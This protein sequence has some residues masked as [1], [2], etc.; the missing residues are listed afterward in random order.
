MTKDTVE[1]FQ[2]AA[3]QLAKKLIA[4]LLIAVFLL[5]LFPASSLA[6]SK[7][8]GVKAT[9]SSYNSIK[10]SWKKVTGASGYYVYQASSKTGKYS[11]VKTITSGSTLSYTKSSLTSGKAYYYKVKAYQTVNKVK[12]ASAYSSIVSAKPIPAKPTNFK[13]SSISATSA[14][15]AWKKVTGASGYEIY[16]ATSKTGKY[17]KIATSTKGSSVSYT[18]KNLVT[19]KSYYYKLR[20]YKKVA[21]KKVYGLYSPVIRAIPTKAAAQVAP[22]I[23]GPTSLA[24]AQGYAKTSSSIYTITGKPTPEV[25][26]TAGN[27]KIT[28][29]AN[30]KKLDIAPGLAAGSYKVTLSAINGV[31]P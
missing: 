29:N 19:G 9:S 24:L 4:S 14:K 20:A 15:I 16:R 1:V 23:S 2:V 21:N 11:L 8:T 28:W 7:P 6:I 22:K 18:S 31:K 25:T 5:V 10:V 30:T 26:K 3:K 27:D 12:K 13:L 17:T